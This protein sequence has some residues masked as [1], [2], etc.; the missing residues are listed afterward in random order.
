[1]NLRETLWA[2]SEA[3]KTFEGGTAITSENCREAVQQM[4]MFEELVAMAKRKGAIPYQITEAL[5]G[6]V[7]TFD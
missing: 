5:G 6:K 1:M 4:V 2:L 7:I 3:G